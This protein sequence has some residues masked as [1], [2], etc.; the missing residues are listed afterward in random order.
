MEGV[1]PSHHPQFDVDLPY[2][3]LFMN[4]HLSAE[5]MPYKLNG[6]KLDEETRLYYYG[7]RYTFLYVTYHESWHR[8]F[9][10]TWESTKSE[11]K[12]VI[13][14]AL[15][16]SWDNVP[17][18]FQHSQASYAQQKL[19]DA[20]LSASER[21]EYVNHLNKVL[22]GIATFSVNKGRVDLNHFKAGNSKFE[23]RGHKTE[24][25]LGKKQK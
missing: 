7:A 17:E 6:K 15:D 25:K 2:G 8:Y 12:T 14:Q 1:F 13:M 9:P 3:E 5:E 4:V 23:V 24:R 20:Q 21:T 18:D 11:V 19:N 16:N 10:E 22:S